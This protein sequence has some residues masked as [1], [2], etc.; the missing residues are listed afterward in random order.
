VLF[1]PEKG[2]ACCPHRFAA[3]LATIE[4]FRQDRAMRLFDPPRLAPKDFRQAALAAAFSPE[5]KRMLW[6]AP[7]KVL[8]SIVART[9]CI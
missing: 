7:Q 3:W 1:R 8:A 6:I 9:G 5:P 4:T 2:I